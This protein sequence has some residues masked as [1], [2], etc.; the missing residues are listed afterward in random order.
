MIHI[1]VLYSMEIFRRVYCDELIDIKMATKTISI[2]E[3]AKCYYNVE[4]EQDVYIGSEV[5]IGDNAL[6]RSGVSIQDRV[7]IGEHVKLGVSVK[8]AKEVCVEGYTEIIDNT[9][10]PRF[11][12]VFPNEP[13]TNNGK[14]S[15]N[16]SDKRNKNSKVRHDLQMPHPGYQFIMQNGKCTSVKRYMKNCIS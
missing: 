10:I 3:T 4:I 16:G 15:V 9:E 13:Q 5:L 14:N 7:D 1:D 8:L 2:D 6:L 11:A 12:R